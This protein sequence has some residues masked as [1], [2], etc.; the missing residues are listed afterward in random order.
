LEC[1]LPLKTGACLPPHCDPSFSCLLSRKPGCPTFVKEKE[2]HRR[3][4]TCQSILATKVSTLHKSASVCRDQEPNLYRSNSWETKMKRTSE[5]GN[6]IPLELWISP[7]RTRP[8]KVDT[9]RTSRT[10]P[11]RTH[12]TVIPVSGMVKKVRSRLKSAARRNCLSQLSIN[13]PANL[14]GDFFGVPD[15]TL[16]I[17]TANQLSSIQ[18]TP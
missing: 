12:R 10:L 7:E 18:E 16:F 1:I 4:A 9:S 3:Q 6:Q 8:S 5:T 11:R 14:L 17:L 15:R 13:P 2:S